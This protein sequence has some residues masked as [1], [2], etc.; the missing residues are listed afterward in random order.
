MKK[1]TRK[2]LVGVLLAVLV[3]AAVTFLG[4]LVP[5]D[6]IVRWIEGL[7]PWGPIALVGAY[8]VATVAFVPGTLLTLASG[9]L[10]GVLGGSLSVIAGSNLG[11][12][13]AFLVARAVGRERLA[14]RLKGQKRIEALDAAVGEQGFKIVVLTRLAPVL[15]FNALNY[16]FG[17]TRVSFRDYALGSL[18]GMLPFTVAYVYLGSVVGMV[19]GVRGR[20]RETTPLEWTLLVAGLAATL[21]FSFWTARIAK[22]AMDERLKETS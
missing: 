17:V 7:G 4:R 15:P 16:A 5:V 13:A 14:N 2:W 11:A 10:F 22:R 18:V 21:V 8:V 20:D 1:T 3:L 6:D 9:A 19:A 12:N